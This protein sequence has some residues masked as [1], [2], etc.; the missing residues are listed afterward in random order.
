MSEDPDL[1]Q[2]PRS[3]RI[4]AREIGSADRFLDAGHNPF[5]VDTDHLLQRREDAGRDC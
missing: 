2:A 4:R 1:H 5:V 3:R